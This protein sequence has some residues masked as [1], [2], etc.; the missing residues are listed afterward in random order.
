MSFPSSVAVGD[1][2]MEANKLPTSSGSQTASWVLRA[3]TQGTAAGLKCEKNICP[4]MMVGNGSLP[5]L[6]AGQWATVRLSAHRNAN[7]SGDGHTSGKSRLQL[8]VNN[9]LLLDASVGT[10]NEARGAGKDMHCSFC[11]WLR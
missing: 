6:Q 1:E 10:S 5:T 7:S 4:T 8:W 2:G 11:C 9:Q 3:G